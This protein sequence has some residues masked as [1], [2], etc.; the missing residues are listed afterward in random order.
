M[1]TSVSGPAPSHTQLPF[2]GDVK[3]KLNPQQKEV[4]DDI[5]VSF[6]SNLKFTVNE[7]L[8][9]IILYPSCFQTV[10]GN[11]GWSKRETPLARKYNPQQLG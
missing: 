1:D 4:L 8:N 9:V 2:G 3:S 6:F 10:E 7:A 11:I 5:S